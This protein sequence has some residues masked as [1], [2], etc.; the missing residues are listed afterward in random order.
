MPPA[1]TARS[2]PSATSAEQRG[3]PHAQRPPPPTHACRMTTPPQR[4]RDPQPISRGWELAAAAAGGALVAVALAALAGLELASAVW[5]GGW[6]W[7]HGTETVIHVLGG[8]LHGD[9]GRGLPPAQPRQV[10]G[11][12]PVSA[13]AAA[14]ELALLAPAVISAVLISRSRRPGD[15]RGG[16]ATRS[17]A[18]QALGLRQLRAG[19]AVIR[20]DRYPS[21][22]SRARLHRL[23]ST[24][25]DAIRG[26]A[27]RSVPST[28]P[29]PTSSAPST[30]TPRPPARTPKELSR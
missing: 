7:P 30:R 16:M 11:P 26:R 4:R 23:L 2:S 5:G 10:A 14:A 19:R 25:G 6:V 9:P 13:C 18:E 27:H 17:E 22:G 15:A 21:L 8:L 1:G 29:R 20:P 12:V 24:V 3:E 28:D